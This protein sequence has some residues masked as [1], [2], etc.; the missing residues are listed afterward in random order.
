MDRSEFLVVEM[1]RDL[2]IFLLRSSSLH[3]AHDHLI[4]FLSRNLLAAKLPVAL[5]NERS[6]IR[7][8]VYPN[9]KKVLFYSWTSFCSIDRYF[10]ED[11]CEIQPG[12]RSN[13]PYV[14]RGLIRAVVIKARPIEIV[15]WPLRR[16][17]AD[18]FLPYMSK[19]M[20]PVD[21]NYLNGYCVDPITL[22]AQLEGIDPNEPV[23]AGVYT[24]HDAY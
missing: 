7:R 13:F 5:T 19:S 16:K 12:L 20:I 1:E 11:E 2:Y 24:S 4:F 22:D 17:Q 9:G 8:T 10:D 6:L 14:A 23:G 3:H 18:I 15:G 21:D